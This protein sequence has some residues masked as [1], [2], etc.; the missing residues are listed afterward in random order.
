M[1]VRRKV[2][3]PTSA[4]EFLSQLTPSGVNGAVIAI[5]PKTADIVGRGYLGG[6]MGD[7]PKF[8]DSHSKHNLYWTP[9]ALTHAIDGKAKKSDIESMRWV[10]LDLD[11]PS[12]SALASTRKYPLPPTMIIASGGGFN[13]YW[14]LA[15][16]VHAN[17]N[18]EQLEDANKR[19]ILDLGA[20]KGTQN[21]DRILRLPFTTNYPTKTKMAR[22][23]VPVE[24]RLV[25]YHPERVY[26]L[27]DFPRLTHDERRIWNGG[28]ERVT[29]ND[30][31]A[32]LLRKVGIDV[33]AGM[34]DA[35]IHAKY[36]SSDP[37]AM[38]QHDPI[39]AVQRCIDKCRKGDGA[40]TPIVLRSAWDMIVHPSAPP[41]WLLKPYLEQEV[42][43]VMAGDY[44]TFKSF[45]CLDWSL[46]V[47]SGQMWHGDSR[48][49]I[50]PQQVV[51]IS[52]EGRSL[53]KRIRAWAKHHQVDDAAL[54]RIKFYSIEMGINLSN[55]DQMA[56]LVAAID[57]LG[58][59]PVMIVVD[60]LTKNSTAVE[61][62][63]SNMQAFLNAI[64]NE[65]RLRYRC[66]VLL[67]HHVGH[68]DKG[69]VRGPISLVGNTE[70]A[71]MV[72]R[73]GESLTLHT[74]RL[75]DSEEPEDFGLRSHVIDLGI[76]DEDQPQSSLVLMPA[77]LSE[78]RIIPKGA[79]QRK[80]WD[81]LN[82]AERNEYNRD[83]LRALCRQLIGKTRVGEV[84]D[85][86]C[87]SGWLADRG[88]AWEF[89]K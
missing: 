61:E 56:A 60:T 86:L 31:S 36:D 72:Y 46:H 34:S 7:L 48:K 11:D 15:K 66:T 19:V 39:R 14:A 53:T 9:N 59:V 87:N 42:T 67:V 28:S 30:R 5:D 49:S 29:P 80:V 73:T 13:V 43:A 24:A 52:A 58:A 84:L 4:V 71:Y 37:H 1:T 64:A 44:G 83:D 62:S 33:R 45:L 3:A 17:G 76:D 63:N 79:N 41:K 23:R 27:N 77:K 55:P 25:E 78:V 12:D 8:I 2:R 74:V 50:E 70:A 38:A 26:A 6:E 85:S 75:K 54:K 10:H 65:L 57:A 88:S 22:G 89:L 40:P 32:E 82:A 35:A 16:P 51:F 18:I 69:R 47:A 81:A 68:S 21:L 20:D